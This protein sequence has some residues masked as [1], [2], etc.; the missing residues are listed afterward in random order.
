MITNRSLRF[1]LGALLLLAPLATVAAQEMSD[2]MMGNDEGFYVRV[3]YGVALPATPKIG[4]TTHK[5]EIGL[6]GGQLGFGYAIFGL[7]PEVSAGYRT[8]TIKDTGGDGSIT[9]LDVIGSVYYDTD[10]ALSLYIGVGGGISSINVTESSGVDPYSA[11]APAFQAAAGLG[12][13][14]TEDLTV[15][16]GYR[17]TGTLEASFKDKDNKDKGKQDIMLGHSAEVGIR[18]SF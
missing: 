14:L 2:D 5:T 6:L 10:G 18:F 16:L 3:S 13:A 8:A 9:S 11:V 1:A 7:R 4:D 12:Y 17:L 15:T